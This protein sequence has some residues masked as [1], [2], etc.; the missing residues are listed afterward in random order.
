MSI[1][2]GRSA[3]A[4]FGITQWPIGSTDEAQAAGYD[5]TRVATCCGGQAAKA[6]GLR[7]CPVFNTCQFHL[8]SMG[9]F[10][11]N[12]PRY[13]G[14]RFIDPADGEVAQDVTKCYAWTL[15]MQAKADANAA[16]RRTSGGKH[17]AVIRVI[18][19]EGEE[20]ITRYNLPI[21]GAGEVVSPMPEMIDILEANKVPYSTRANEVPIGR[22]FFELK[23]VVPRHP[24]P[25]EMNMDSWGQRVAMMDIHNEAR[26]RDF[27]DYA[28]SAPTEMPTVS[29]AKP[30]NQWG[31]AGKP[32]DE[33]G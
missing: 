22:K 24:R 9:A 8:K 16:L 33:Q 4:E 14:Y 15:T 2:Q 11:G 19:Q 27:V 23:R 29:D 30:R 20:I 3:L 7:P 13:I 26:D 28:A 32:K 17:G 25:G 18:A 5:T 6:Q 21:N 12:G 31:R 1:E 10:K